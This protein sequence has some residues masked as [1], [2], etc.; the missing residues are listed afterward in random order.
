MRITH[1][2]E[3][4]AKA[5]RLLLLLRWYLH[6]CVCVSEGA[7][8]FWCLQLGESLFEDP[9]HPLRFHKHPMQMRRRR[10]NGGHGERFSMIGAKLLEVWAIDSDQQLGKAVE[11][12]GISFWC[13]PAFI[14][15]AFAPSFVWCGLT[16]LMESKWKLYARRA[17]SRRLL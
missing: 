15:S 9:M 14:K 11:F 2:A 1:T 12:N 16:V 3:W 6:K 10:Q 4:K 7:V 8:K 13:P 17:L 5:N